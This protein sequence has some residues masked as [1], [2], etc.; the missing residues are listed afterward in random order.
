VPLARVAGATAVGAGIVI[1]GLA[2]LGAHAEVL[3]V[4]LGPTSAGRAIAD[5]LTRGAA[6]ISTSRGVKLA[7]G[8]AEP[9]GRLGAVG[10]VTTIR[11]MRRGG[12]GTAARGAARRFSA[13]AGGG[14]G[15]GGGGVRRRWKN[16]NGK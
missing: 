10:C 7:T 2:A 14:S 13:I 9:T 4:A 3:A 11:G 5:R 16:R 1:A 8:A 12:G 6:G 15:G